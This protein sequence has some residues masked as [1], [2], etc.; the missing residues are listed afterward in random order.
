VLILIEFDLRPIADG[1]FTSADAKSG[2]P[3]WCAFAEEIQH[4]LTMRGVDVTVPER[5]A[6]L[7]HKLNWYDQVFQQHADIPVGFWPKGTCLSE[8]LAYVPCSLFIITFT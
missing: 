8:V 7:V 2:I 5:M 4:A 1:K 6:E 3:G